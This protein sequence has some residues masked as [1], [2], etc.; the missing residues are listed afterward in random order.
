MA[1]SPPLSSSPMPRLRALSSPCP[2]G[3]SPCKML[4]VLLVLFP[5]PAPPAPLPRA[6]RLSPSARRAWNPIVPAATTEGTGLV[7]PCGGGDQVM[8]LRVGCG[9]PHSCS[10]A[11]QPGGPVLDP[12]LCPCG[13]QEWAGVP[14]G[15]GEHWV[16][17]GPGPAPGPLPVLPA[18]SLEQKRNF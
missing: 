17:G 18:S 16:Q 15:W 3:C 8:L 7:S 12:S 14:H 5:P 2:W 11:P 9:G 6:T 10:P 1:R 4:S 13:G